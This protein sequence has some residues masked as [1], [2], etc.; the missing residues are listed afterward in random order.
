MIQA[1]WANLRWR[2]TL[3]R[4]DL[5]V[6]FGLLMSLLSRYEYEVRSV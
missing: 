6:I 1:D 3:D 5:S 4:I 2:S